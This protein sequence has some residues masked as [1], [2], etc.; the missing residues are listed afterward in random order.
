M[1]GRGDPYGVNPIEEPDGHTKSRHLLPFVTSVQRD[2][3]VLLL[4][5]AGPAHWDMLSQKRDNSDVPNP[6]QGTGL[7]FDASGKPVRLLSHL[8]FPLAAA[9]SVGSRSIDTRTEVEHEVGED[10]VTFRLRDTIVAVRVVAALKTDGSSVP[11]KLIVDASGLANGVGRITVTHDEAVPERRG[12]VALWMRAAKLGEE[13]DLAGEMSACRA[14]FDGDRATV[15]VR[16]RKG[17]LKVVADLGEWKRIEAVGRDPETDG[18][19][20][21]VNGRDI[22]KEILV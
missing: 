10:V 13:G 22:G 7:S 19:V 14:D 18:A 3:E 12:T 17:E 4:A 11:A 20:L 16:G 15:S 9:V 6:F 1:D 8:T 2:A 21:W 5:S